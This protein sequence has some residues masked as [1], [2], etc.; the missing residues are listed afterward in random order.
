ML[1]KYFVFAEGCPYNLSK[2]FHRLGIHHAITFN[3]FGT[4]K[5]FVAS[6]DYGLAEQIV[7]EKEG[8]GGAID[9]KEKINY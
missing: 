9:R 4:S 2:R 8:L 6:E 7:I 5:V 3:R 1:T